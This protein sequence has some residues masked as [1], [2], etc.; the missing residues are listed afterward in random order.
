MLLARARCPCAHA[1]PGH[2][3]ASRSLS[4]VC[5]C[6][7]ALLASCCYKTW[8]TLP[9]V[10]ACADTL[11]PGIYVE[12]EL[13][14]YWIYRISQASATRRF[15]KRDRPSLNCNTAGDQER[16]AGDI[17][18]SGLCCHLGVVPRLAVQKKNSM[19]YLAVLE[20]VILMV[21]P[22]FW[23]LVNFYP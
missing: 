9:R 11:I 1:P 14:N 5:A 20:I 21:N 13:F 22:K 8:E 4:S 7:L 18:N 6:A 23:G 17:L 16:A 12:V 3:P 15:A 2:V 19:Q 10:C